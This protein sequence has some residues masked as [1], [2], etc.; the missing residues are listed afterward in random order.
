[1]SLKNCRADWRG[2]LRRGLGLA[3]LS[4]GLAFAQGEFRVG[5]TLAAPMARSLPAGVVELEWEA[6]MPAD[7]NPK[8]ALDGIDLAA[9]SDNDPKASALLDKL[10]QDLDKAPVVK[11]LDGKRVR[12]A[13]FVVTLERNDKGVS[14]FLLVPYYGACI[15]TPPPPANQIIH[16][17]PKTPVAPEMAIFPVYVTGTLKTVAVT[18]AEGAAGY[19]IADGKVE[20]YPWRRQRR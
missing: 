11:S 4:S 5:E 7:W 2:A 16:V 18:T 17:L 8:K 19:Q 13:G 3:V 9:L 6:L 20:E 12:I 1:M 15:H 14:E 10:R